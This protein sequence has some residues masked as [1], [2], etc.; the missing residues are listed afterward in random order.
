[1]TPLVSVSNL[2]VSFRLGRDSIVEAVRGVSFEVP[3]DGT[4]ALVGESGS[5][6]TVSA[7]SILRLL[8]EN[9]LVDPAGRIEFEGENL[10]TARP[11]HLR[12][13]RGRDITAV[14]QEPMT[15]LNPVFT[16]GD[17]IAEVLQWHRGLSR[18]QALAQSAELLA[19]VGIAQPKARIGAYPHEL[20]G[21]QQQRVMI[22]MAIANQPKLLIADEPTTA[23]DVTIQ[24]QVLELIARLRERH[25]MSVLF[26]S[27]D[28]ALVGEIADQ[29]VVMRDGEVQECG[30]VE[31]VFRSPQ[32]PY[33]KGLLLCRPRLDQRPRRLPVIDDF[34]S[35]SG[36]RSA[37]PLERPAASGAVIEARG[38]C[39][40]FRLK[41]GLFASKV[42]HAVRGV[43][44]DLARGR[45]VGLVGESGSGK[46][47]V[48]MLLMRLLEASAGDV[49]FDGVNLLAVSDAQ[50]MAYRRRIQVIF[51]NPYASLNPRFTIG[52]ILTE[53]MRVHRLGS[54]ETERNERARR[55]LQRVELPP[56]ALYKYPHEFSGGQRQRIAIARALAVEPEIL[57]CDESVSALDVSVQATVLNLLLDLQE[58]QGLAYLFIS[59]DLAVVKYM[60]DEILVMREGEVVERGPSE[61]L[62][63]APQHDY[64][65]KLL[66]AIPRGIE[67]R[68][69]PL[70]A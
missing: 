67:G 37:V 27:H 59:H 17:Q 2:R 26:I 22:A 20:S 21:G 57:I 3:A 48:G 39:K 5:G 58:E 13:I 18:R 61:A 50:M 4:L 69:A 11:E 68:L 44:F 65:K 66:D 60:A 46:T 33:T 1:M 31:R 6:K 35:A 12:R 7:M 32:H 45:T 36:P 29:V 34:L 62:F 42:L 53:P 55:L 9:A 25:R 15:S 52:Q 54:G 43:S 41:T 63:R 30:P 19:E 47:T 56:E 10:L 49:R 23:L 70:A 38:L 64:T 28:L 51:Q 14:F 24:R 16:V 40:H 8:P